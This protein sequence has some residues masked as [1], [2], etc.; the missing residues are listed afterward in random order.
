MALA[1]V[2]QK[3][4]ID[5][6]DPSKGYILYK[7]N[8]KEPTKGIISTTYYFR[9]TDCADCKDFKGQDAPWVK[10]DVYKVGLLHYLKLTEA[11]EFAGWKLVIYTDQLSLEKPTFRSNSAVNR[12]RA[13][14]HEKEWA[15]IAKHPNAVFA[16]VHWPEYE[17]GKAGDGKTIDNAVLRA[18]RMK[19]FHDFADFPV[20]IRDADTLFENIVK[21]R[22]MVPELIRW[23]DTLRSEFKK[24]QEKEPKYQLIVAS[25][26]NYHRQWH[27]HPESGINTTGCYAAVTSSL[28]KIDEWAD[29]SLWRKCLAYIRKYSQ[30]VDNGGERQPNNIGKPTY[31]GKD[32]QLL[33]Y[34]V[35]PAIFDKIYFYYLEYIQVEGVKIVDSK[36]TPFANT[37]IKELGINRYPSPYIE[38]LGEQLLPLDE[39]VGKKRKDENVKTET[40]ILDPKIIPLSLSPDTNRVLQLIFRYFITATTT[41]GQTGGGKRRLRRHKTVKRRSNSRKYHRRR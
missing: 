38:S 41:K 40:T 11:P 34:V 13:E 1:A 6:D 14:K 12:A 4:D 5:P 8:S 24:I 39:T 18:L 35:L 31:I 15:E 16:E 37:L 30:I 26:P 28:G 2:E 17:V 19:A 29:G 10:T 9:E 7:F 27:V 21:V 25:Q 20:F 23:E 3:K 36:E 22:S 32:E 33:S